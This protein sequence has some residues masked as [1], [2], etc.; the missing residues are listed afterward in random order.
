LQNVLAVFWQG[1]SDT[2]RQ[3]LK[4]P[5]NVP[6]ARGCPSPESPAGDAIWVRDPTAP[7]SGPEKN[8]AE[9]PLSPPGRDGSRPATVRSPGAGDAFDSE[10][11]QHRVMGSCDLV[12][13]PQQGSWSSVNEHRGSRPPALEVMGSFCAAIQS[14]FN[15]LAVAMGGFSPSAWT[16]VHGW[17]ASPTAAT[18]LPY[19]VTGSLSSRPTRSGALTSCAS[20]CRPGS[21]SC[22]SYRTYPSMRSSGN[23]Q[24]VEATWRAGAH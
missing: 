1:F 14:M 10:H 18:R 3:G 20:Y 5:P 7:E 8:P 17:A 13:P 4:V 22:R 11:L 21:P 2:H 24:R 16:P 23:L 6:I 9:Q 19:T 12:S 15:A